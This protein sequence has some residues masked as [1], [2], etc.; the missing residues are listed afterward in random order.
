MCNS[1]Y[2]ALN[3]RRASVDSKSMSKRPRQVPTSVREG[4]V[5]GSLPKGAQYHALKGMSYTPSVRDLN[6]KARRK[7]KRDVKRMDWE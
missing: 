1:W 6:R 3:E 7:A 2:Q 4:D 5:K